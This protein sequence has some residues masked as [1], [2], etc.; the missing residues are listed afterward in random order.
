MANPPKGLRDVGGNLFK[1][2][3]GNTYLLSS[4]RVR[5]LKLAD[6]LTVMFQLYRSRLVMAATIFLVMG[7][8][9]GNWISGAAIGMLVFAAF[10]I[11]F[12]TWMIPRMGVYKTLK[13]PYPKSGLI[14]GVSQQRKE[15]LLKNV[16]LSII[17]CAIFGWNLFEQRKSGISLGDINGVLNTILSVVM[18]LG[19]G[20]YGV[21][22]AREFFRR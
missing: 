5:I 12:H 11:F 15:N 2:A 22:C 7:Y 8:Y 20:A 13:K 4:D 16:V 14:A 6:R 10:E 18:I 9:G 17:M 21:L 1:D 19:P 3:S